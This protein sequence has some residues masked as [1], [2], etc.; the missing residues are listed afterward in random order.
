MHTASPVYGHHW[1]EYENYDG[2]CHITCFYM[3]GTVLHEGFGVPLPANVIGLILFTLSLFLK[4]VKV[5]WVEEASQFLIRHM[6]LLFAPIVAGTMVF[7]S[8]IG[9][10]ALTIVISLFMSTFGV[11]L[12]TGW[13]VKLMS[14]RKMKEGERRYDRSRA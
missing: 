1:K 9:E 10:Q 7:F 3:L 6:L 12:F 13:T 8:L 2:I 11:L 14:G 4:I 5:S